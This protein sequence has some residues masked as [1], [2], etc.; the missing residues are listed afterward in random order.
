M[1]GAACSEIFV[2]RLSVFLSRI[3]D[4]RVT[5]RADLSAVADV[6]EPHASDDVIIGLHRALFQNYGRG[7]HFLMRHVQVF[8]CQ[9]IA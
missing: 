7:R 6:N 2:F 5:A 3:I 4:H 9:P 8:S 1:H